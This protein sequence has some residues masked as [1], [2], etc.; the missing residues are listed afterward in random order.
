MYDNKTLIHPKK[1]VKEMNKFINLLITNEYGTYS[2]ENGLEKHK[3]TGKMVK[4]KTF[5][6]RTVGWDNTRYEIEYTFSG[7]DEEDILADKTFRKDFV[8]RCPLARGFADI[9]LTLLHEI[10]HKHSEQPFNYGE[11]LHA[12]KLIFLTAKDIVEA[13]EMYFKIPNEKNAT[14]WAIEWLQDPEHRK[15]AKA[16]EKEFFKC[17]E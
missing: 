7:A 10:G 13:N 6:I 8:N 17:F 9:T 14:N 4:G 16:F 1:V 3:Y 5:G 12:Q 11:Y 2:L 15:L